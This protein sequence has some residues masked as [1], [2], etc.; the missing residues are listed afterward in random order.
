MPV[1]MI[2][3]KLNQRAAGVEPEEGAEPAPLEDG[4]GGA[5][6]G[7]DAEQK[8]GGGLEWDDD[9]AEDQHQDQ[10]GKDDYDAEVER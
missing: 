2:G 9:R 6:G 5:E 3:M 10:D 7:Q 4:G 1:T 8:A